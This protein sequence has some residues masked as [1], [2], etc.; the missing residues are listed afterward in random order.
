M[1]EHL[2]HAP[3]GYLTLA[4]DG[5]VLTINQTL[6]N[7]LGYDINELRG[8]HINCI[9]TVSGRSFFQLYFFPLIQLQGTVEEMY[10]PLQ[11]KGEHPLPFLLNALRK[12]TEKETATH[13]MFTLMKRRRE[14]EQSILEIKR[15]MEEQNR[16]K[17]EMITE[18]ELL[19]RQ[20]EHKQQELVEMN[21]RLKVLAETDGLTG[22]KNR[23]SFQEA[24]SLNMSLCQESSLPLSLL[25]LD[26]DHFKNINDTFGHLA[27]DKVLQVLA[28]LLEESTKEDE[29]VA[30]YGG[31]EFAV[32]LPNADQPQALQVGE[33]IRSLAEASY[34]TSPSFTVSI[35]AVTMSLEDTVTS[36][37]SKADRALY[38]SKRNG[39]NRVTHFDFLHR[40][41][42]PNSLI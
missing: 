18:L 34:S 35:G 26:V 36:L 37:Q 3:C 5:T 9:M 38:S 16:I 17:E 10:L 14:Y 28:L 15:E 21:S 8:K 29:V 41:A 1:D 6:L 27:G 39:R 22:L 40:S 23:R 30:R 7:L 42:G 24:L 19:Q 11:P 20:L 33:K 12:V 4:D 32:I 2:N 31:E 25:L 13:C